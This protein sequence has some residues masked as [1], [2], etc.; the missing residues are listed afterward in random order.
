MPIHT[1]TH[2]CTHILTDTNIHTHTHTH[3]IMHTLIHTLTHIHILIHTHLKLCTA[4]CFSCVFFFV[5]PF[6]NVTI[7]C[8]SIFLFVLFLSLF[9]DTSV[10]MAFQEASG[11]HGSLHSCLPPPSLFYLWKLCSCLCCLNCSPMQ[12]ESRLLPFPPLGW[13]ALP[14]VLMLSALALFFLLVH[15]CP[16][17]CY[18][19]YFV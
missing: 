15:A 7:S 11:D 18:M 14:L 4:S 17:T 1:K 10:W 3:K 16:I 5:S 8:N 9:F 2:S 19:L 13:A 6:F 12:V